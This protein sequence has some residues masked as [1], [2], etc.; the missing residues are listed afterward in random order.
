MKRGEGLAG[1]YRNKACIQTPV[2]FKERSISDMGSAESSR[3]LG[4]QM[5]L[6]GRKSGPGYPEQSEWSAETRPRWM[7]R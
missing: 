7:Q 1:R 3:L 4:R 2:W 6:G 5:E